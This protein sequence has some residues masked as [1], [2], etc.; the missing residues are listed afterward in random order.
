MQNNTPIKRAAKSPW[1]RANHAMPAVTRLM[2]REAFPNALQFCED[3]SDNDNTHQIASGMPN[4]ELS[5]LR[6]AQEQ[7]LITK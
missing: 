6:Y 2:D 5:T 4:F 7:T 3:D 1:S